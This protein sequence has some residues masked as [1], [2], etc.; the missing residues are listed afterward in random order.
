[1]KKAIL[2]SFCLSLSFLTQTK[3]QTGCS[4][5]T[6]DLGCTITPIGPT[7]CPSILPTDTAQKPYSQGF[8]FFLPK[9]FT[10]AGSGQK[11]KFKQLDVISVSNLPFGMKWTA[12]DYKGVSTTT[13]YPDS[14]PTGGSERG[15]V[16]LCGT[17]LVAYDDSIKIDVVAKV[18]TVTGGFNVTQ[19][20][21]FYLPLKI[22]AGQG[23][24]T[25]FTM[26]NSIGCD[27]LSVAFTPLFASNGSKLYTYDWKFGDT[28]TSKK[29]NPTHTYS[30]P[31]KY[32]V[33]GTTKIHQLVLDAIDFEVFTGTLWCGDIEEV[34]YPIVGCQGAPDVYFEL[35]S[36]SGSKVFTSQRI[37]NTTTP[38]WS[39]LN[40]A[41]TDPPYSI[42]FYD[43]DTFTNDD[44]LGTKVFG[45]NDSGTVSSA[46]TDFST[47]LKIIMQV[48]QTFKDTDTVTV[49]APPIIGNII[50]SVDSVC[51]GDSIVL[52]VDTGYTYQWYKDSVKQADGKQ[53]TYVVKEP[54][55]F[56]VEVTS[57]DG[58][59]VTSNVYDAKIIPIP[60]KPT[61]INL[62]G[63]LKTFQQNFSYKWFLDGV[64]IPTAVYDTLTVTATGNYTLELT[65]SGGCSRMSDTVFVNYT[66]PV[67]ASIE[68]LELVYQGFSVFPNPT[69]DK[70]TIQ[71]ELFKKQDVELFVSDVSG[72]IVYSERQS[73]SSPYF[74]KEVDLSEL[75]Q[76][77]YFLDV[78]VGG[79]SI[80]RKIIKQ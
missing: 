65:S 43:F 4:I 78:R 1:M 26:S 12:Y 46:N 11:V 29:E 16:R 62:S 30:K 57:K 33:I 28:K 52:S 56:W 19:N 54:K 80:N 72:K 17:P 60:P 13:F 69:N 10:D 70:I 9:E 27:S 8:T 15:C 58:C 18:V 5:C 41:L 74:Q 64:I 34:S 48:A 40:I 77:M 53:A 14:D 6:I 38:S 66:P 22:V 31:G 55:K 24:N 75:S 42:S 25:V 73:I 23:G 59:T 68:T 76:G 2:L 50:A 7:L 49:Y 45:A 35:F 36:S 71:M 3:A 20:V 37:D 44:F 51:E 63:Q 67:V 61:F 21:T 39:N 79:N 47:K 32:G